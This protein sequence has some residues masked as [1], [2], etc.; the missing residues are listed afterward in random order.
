MQSLSFQ[1]CFNI[2]FI[3]DILLCQRVSILSRF[4]SSSVPVLPCL[5]AI[6]NDRSLKILFTVLFIAS[7]HWLLHISGFLCTHMHN[8]TQKHCCDTGA[9]ALLLHVHIS[10]AKC[11]TTS[12]LI[13]YWLASRL[14]FIHQPY[15]YSCIPFFHHLHSCQ[16]VLTNLKKN[17]L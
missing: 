14:A 1:S 9:L 6:N 3:P 5:L 12:L 11:S 7:L 16:S 15:T 17:N 4:C 10:T 8:F 13:I 2:L